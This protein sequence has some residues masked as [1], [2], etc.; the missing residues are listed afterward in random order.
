MRM[1]LIK[2]TANN[3]CRTLTSGTHSSHVAAA[4]PLL[5]LTSFMHALLN[6]CVT[7]CMAAQA[8]LLAGLCS[9]QWLFRMPGLAQRLLALAEGAISMPG[10]PLEAAQPPAMLLPPG[11]R[12]PV[13]TLTL[14]AWAQRGR[15]ASEA[16]LL[17]KEMLISNSE[18]LCEWALWACDHDSLPALPYAL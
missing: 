5:L 17:L 9:A 2:D 1:S 8:A 18:L 13:S 7:L 12:V 16:L 6:C 3:R 11:A 4:S 14:G 10:W 15:V